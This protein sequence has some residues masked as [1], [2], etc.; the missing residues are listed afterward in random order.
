M[1]LQFYHLNEMPFNVTPDP[2]FLFF[3]QEHR[4]AYEALKYGIEQRK[5]FMTLTGEVGCGKTTVSRAVLA[6]LPESTRTALILNPSLSEQQL[7]RAILID[8]GIHPAGHDLLAHIEQL[9][10]FLLQCLNQGQ[11]VSIM[12]DEAQDLSPRVMEQ[13]RLLSNLETD[14][15]KLMQLILVGQPELAKRL[16]QHEWR[17]LRQRIM[18]HCSLTALSLPE[19][20]QYIRFRLRTAH[21]TPQ[22]YF[23]KSALRLIYKKARGIPR[24]INMICDRALLAGYIT[25]TYAI[26]ATEV[27]K[28]ISEIKTM[29]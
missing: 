23:D 4:E 16:Q 25:S 14:Q 21:A 10:S 28:A 18:I 29:L 7:L 15:H 2:R 12:I 3:T 9:N 19:M 20:K 5:G 13:I 8:L 27:K 11:N 6:A 24:T 26:T 22:L 1:Y 17:Q